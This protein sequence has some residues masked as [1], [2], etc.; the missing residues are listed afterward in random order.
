[1]SKEPSLIEKLLMRLFWRYDIKGRQGESAK[2][3]Y[4]RRLF[5]YTDVSGMRKADPTKTKFGESRF[6]MWAM[7]QLSK[8]SDYPLERIYL[9]KMYRSDNDPDPHD[10]PFGFRTRIL[11]EGYDDE[12]WE[13]DGNERRVARV[14]PMRFG[15][16]ADREPE[17]LHR[18]RLADEEKPTW[19]LVFV[20]KHV[21][22][23]FFVTTKGPI[24]WRTY[25]NDHSETV[26][27]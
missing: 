11:S 27:E 24:H 22:D 17:H 10:H 8:L 25:L 16:T 4:M 26:I 1:M 7:R 14:I 23:W 21:K 2:E 13:W 12:V 15:A 5:I 3:L 18:V 9:H 6:W 19:T 20:G